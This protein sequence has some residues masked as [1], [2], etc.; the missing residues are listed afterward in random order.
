MT[1]SVPRAALADG[2]LFRNDLILAFVVAFVLQAACTILMNR[3]EPSPVLRRRLG[4]LVVAGG[5]LV[6][7]LGA[8]VLVERYGGPGQAYSTLFGSATSLGLGALQINSG[9]NFLWDVPIENGIAIVI[10]VLITAMF[11]FSAVSGVEKGIQFLSNLSGG[12]TLALMVF[13]LI[14]GPTVFRVR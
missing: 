7:S 11:V 12:L 6:V 4:I 9:L 10:V 8:F 5:V 1:S 13:F 14:V 2:T 3:Y